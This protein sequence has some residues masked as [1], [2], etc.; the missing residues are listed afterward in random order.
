MPRFSALVR[1]QR[2]GTL[3]RRKPARSETLH[4]RGADLGP[5]RPIAQHCGEFAF[6]QL[7]RGAAKE[8]SFQLVGITGLPLLAV[9]AFL[10][11]DMFDR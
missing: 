7:Q 11:V 4:H 10:K 9:A 2:A 6:L 1:D 3:F 8:T 5:D